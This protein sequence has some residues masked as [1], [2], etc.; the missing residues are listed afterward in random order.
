MQVLLDEIRE[1]YLKHPLLSNVDVFKNVQTQQIKIETEYLTSDPLDDHYIKTAATLTVNGQTVSSDLNMTTVHDSIMIHKYSPSGKIRATVKIGAEGASLEIFKNGTLWYR[2]PVPPTT[3]IMPVKSWIYM[4]DLMHFSEDESR[5]MYM[6]EDPVPM[7]NV[8][9]LKDIGVTRFKYRDSI[10]DRASMHPNPT[11]FIFDMNKKELFRVHKPAE[12]S[13]RRIVYMH[14]QFADAKGESII[15][16]AINMIGVSD[17][18]FFTNYPKQLTYIK[19]LTCDAAIKGPLGNK[20]WVA[21]PTPVVREN[22]I[23]EVAFFPKLSPDYKTV[24]YYFNEKCHGPSLNSCGLRLMNLETFATETIVAE[25]EEDDPIFSG[26]QGF[27][28]TLSKYCWLN[29]DTIVFNAAHHQ[30]YHVYQVSISKKAVSR[31][32]QGTKFL[33]S[34]SDLFLAKLDEDLFLGKRDCLYKNGLLFVM[35]RN[36]DGS[37]AELFSQQLEDYKEFEIFDETITVGGIEG[38]FAGRARPGEDL[39]KR[40]VIVVIH[41]GPHGIWHSYHTPMIWHH[42]KN[43]HCILNINYTGS[44]GRG[45]KFAR[46]LCGNAG[47]IEIQEVKNFIDHCIKEGKFDP[48]QVKVSSGSYGGFMT[49]TLL[50][51][52]PDLI[53]S[54]SIFNPVTNGFSMWLG[55]TVHKWLGAEFLGHVDKPYKFSERLSDEEA[56]IVKQKSPMFAE[57]SFKGE[58]LLFLGLK[59]DVV[60]PLSTR[61]LF[62]MMRAAKLKVQL[63]EYPE[64]EHMILGVGPNFDYTIKTCMLFAKKHPFN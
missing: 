47:E 2:K 12:T 30:S 25:Q 29:N 56:L 58:L 13:Q 24:S 35:K 50:K 17:Q 4:T 9:K 55:S 38:G 18:T 57:Y 52:Y 44:T 19:G 8:Y 14:P 43:N 49:L 60:P 32:V 61:H 26:I 16:T 3:H 20:L 15:C 33:P 37:F 31:V 59:D 10:G 39:S 34:E 5:F 27:H 54:A 28:L 7:I 63:Y 11:I 62:K 46:N 48:S 45:N 42:L 36:P 41:G 21:T 40:P 64:E 22:L 6:A 23:E 53:A 51:K 1:Q